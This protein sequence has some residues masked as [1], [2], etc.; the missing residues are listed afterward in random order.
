MTIAAIG[1][2]GALGFRVDSGFLYEKQA[3]VERGAR[4]SCLPIFSIEETD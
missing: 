4:R 3:A 2:K 1:T